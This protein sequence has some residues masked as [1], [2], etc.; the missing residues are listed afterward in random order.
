MADTLTPEEK[1]RLTEE[2]TKY[3]NEGAS[4]DDLRQFRDAF[5]SQ[6]KKKGGTQPVSGQPA[7]QPGQPSA[8]S[9]GQKVVT[10]A[11]VSGQPVMKGVQKKHVEKKPYQDITYK[12]EELPSETTQMPETPVVKAAKKDFKQTQLKPQVQLKSTPE[13]LEEIQKKTEKADQTGLILNDYQSTG[14]IYEDL[15]SLNDEDVNVVFTRIQRRPDLYAKYSGRTP[16]EVAN[17][18]AYDTRELYEAD[19]DLVYKNYLADLESQSAKHNKA[20]AKANVVVKDILDKEITPD[21]YSKYTKEKKETTSFGE[22]KAGTVIDMDK[23]D[24]TASAIAE[25]YNLPID[26]DA[27]R[28]IKNELKTGVETEIIR[29]EAESYYAKNYPELNKKRQEMFESGFKADEQIYAKVD[30]VLTS[31]ENQYQQDAKNELNAID[32]EYKTKADQLNAEYAQFSDDLKKQQDAL[33][34]SYQAG[35][36]DRLEYEANWNNLSEQDKVFYE[37]Y[38]KQFPDMTAYVTKANE[39]NSKY[40]RKHQLQRDAI[41]SKADAEMKEAYKRYALEYKE[42]PELLKQIND[43]YRDSFEKATEART[44]KMGTAAQLSINP[45]SSLYQSTASALGG[46]FKGWGGSLDSKALEVLGESMEQTFM[47]PRARAK[48]FSDWVDPQNL[49]LLTGQLAGSMIPSMTASAAV[50]IGTQGAGA[51]VAAQLIAGGLAGWATETVDIVGR[52]YL[53]RFEKTNGNIAE[54]N[55]AAER[56]LQSQYD[57]MFTYAFDALPFVGKAFKFI[58]SKAGR[59]VAGGATELATETA[60]EY[61]QNIA[62]ENIQAGNEP[63]T[64]LNEALKDTKR[65]KE[66]LISVGPVAILGGA[67]QLGSTSKKSEL[68]DAYIAAQQKSSLNTALP[69]QKRQYVQNMVFSKNAKFANGVVGTL[70]TT[71][72]IDEQTSKDLMVEIERAERIKESGKSAGLSGSKLNVYGFYSARAE[73]AE[74]NA[75]K[76]GRDPILHESYKQMAKQYRDAGLDFMKGGKPDLLTITYA[77]GSQAMMMPEDA[78]ALFSDATALD[79]LSKKAVAVSAYKEGG[80]GVK[81]VDEL[82]TRAE[83]YAKK[84]RYTQASTMASPLQTLRENI[85]QRTEQLDAEQADLTEKQ[86]Q[87]EIKKIEDEEIAAFESKVKEFEGKKRDERDLEIE[88]LQQ[89]EALGVN[90]VNA[91]FSDMKPLVA[92]TVERMETGQAAPKSAVNAASD[93]LYAKYK[94][95]TAMKSDSNRMMT[96]AQIESIQAQIEQDLQTLAGNPPSQKT[97]ARDQ[98]NIQGIPGQVRVGQELVQGQPIQGAGQEAT[99]TGGVLQAQEEVTPTTEAAVEQTKPGDIVQKAENVDVPSIQERARITDS[100]IKRKNIFDGVGDFSEQLGGSD[101]ASVPVGHSEIGNAEIIQYANPKTGTIDVIVAGLSDSD[102]VGFYRIYENGKPTNRW[103]SKFETQTASK[104]DFKNMILGVQNALPQGHEY[105]ETTSISTD[106]LRVWNQQLNK[107]YEFQYDENGKLIT[108]PVYINGDAKINILGVPVNKGAFDPINVTNMDTFNKAKEALLPFL[109]K[110]GLNEKNIRAV[111]GSVEIDLPVLRQKVTPTTTEAAPTRISEINNLEQALFENEVQQNET[112]TG[113]LSEQQLTDITSKLD[114]MR[115][116]NKEG[117]LNEIETLMKQALGENL[118]TAADIDQMVEDG[119]VEI[120]CPPGAKKA[121][122]G[123]RMG[124]IP[125]GKWDIVKEFKGKSHENGGIDIEIA[126]GK[127]SYTGKEPNLKAKKGGFFKSIGSGIRNVVSKAKDSGVVSKAKDVGYGYLDTQLGT[128][129][130]VAG[131]KSMQDI[132]DE[133]QYSNDKFDEAANFA[134]KIQGTVFK[135]LPVTAPIASAVGTAGGIVNKVGGIDEKFY[136]PSQHTSGLDKAGNIVSTVG[137]FVGMAV[138][139]ANASG[140]SNALASG[141]DLTAAQQMSV[142]MQGINNILGKTSKGIGMMGFGG[143]NQQPQQQ[144]LQQPQFDP[145]FMPQQ[146]MFNPYQQSMFN[147]Y[148][149]NMLNPY[150]QSQYGMPVQQAY[151]NSMSNMVTINGVNYTPD[152]YG[153]LIPLT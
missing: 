63:W 60:Q 109:E 89:R 3:A 49:T 80:E 94:E 103:S 29:P 111:N 46:V 8:P 92:T 129:G 69:D 135:V 101:V 38:K 50:V 141:G 102:F 20:V 95:L 153:N 47:M 35:Q 110:F 152:Q 15:K 48:E 147:P 139:G 121:E 131:I 108:T 126:G 58:P 91:F 104:E 79:L 53:D 57:I 127:I 115:G 130:D 77:D 66:T 112:G 13:E 140:A 44:K 99:T 41:A 5:I 7:P 146:N 4:D 76:F 86:R 145:G 6:L 23:V 98:E 128:V 151:S 56:S 22:I 32:A 72:Q 39:I 114:E 33:T 90:D 18:Q 10:D 117:G 113:T 62:D 1:K 149:Q 120:K 88:Q 85:R 31:L 43:A 123:M 133:D 34:A 142:D 148:Q 150:Q 143:G 97:E 119:N 11:F 125:G 124:F 28:L 51:P 136:D 16:D 14:D 105:T 74:R 45:V 59:V 144:F 68:T 42:D 21:T 12:R 75:A 9:F 71:G 106:G 17:V 137:S 40:N 138:G 27:W 64:N 67:G 116:Q 2:L 73:G 118:I 87:A 132:I 96:I 81:I 52:S 61:P 37:N 84:N 122:H 83:A 19:R 100:K 26:G 54:A 24:E 82:K 107:G 134:G 78:N 36:I 55:L 65:M 70:F 25:K 30:S 93:Y